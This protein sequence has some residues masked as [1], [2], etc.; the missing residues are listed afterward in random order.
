MRGHLRKRGQN[1][2]A[3]VVDLPHTAHGKRRRKWHSFRGTKSAAQAE[4]ARILHQLQ[5]GDYVEGSRE[6]MDAFLRRWLV[7]SESRVS[8][9]T[10]E[11]YREIVETQIVP[12]LGAIKLTKLHPSHILEAYSYWLRE[13]RRNG[14]GGLSAQ[15]VLHH[16]RLLHKALSQAVKWQLVARNVMDAVDPPSVEKHE[17]RALDESEVATLLDAANGQRLSAPVYTAAITGL[18]RGELV[19]LKWADIDFETAQL[20]VR[21]SVEQTRKGVRFKPT[22]SKQARTV[23]LSVHALEVFRKHRVAQGRERL[24]VGPK[25][26]VLDL[27]F[28]REDGSVWEPELFGKAF[29]G[30]V[31]RAKLG[32]LRLHDL[33]HSCASILLKAGVHV[34]VVSERLGHS[35]IAITLDLYSHILPGL[36]REASD[37][38]EASIDAALNKRREGK[39]GRA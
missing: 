38:I 17:M 7:S 13:G 22:K 18:R 31:K 20:A 25:Y 24:K 2:W 1:S 11:R 14:K 35:T 16:H 33:R 34:K 30:L 27:V 21:R 29:I 39:V 26:N 28:P 3:I 15:T 6:T 12:A 37:K 5:T 23:Q 36:Q 8:G 9:K 32:H 19:G 4:M 10:L